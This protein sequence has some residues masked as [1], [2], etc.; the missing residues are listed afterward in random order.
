MSRETEER[1]RN[2]HASPSLAGHL[3]PSIALEMFPAASSND[4]RKTGS[5]PGP[6]GTLDALASPMHVL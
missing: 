5:S 1:N 2:A 6:D 3:S 4:G